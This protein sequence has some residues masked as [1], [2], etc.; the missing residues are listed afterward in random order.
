MFHTKFQRK[1]IHFIFH[2]FFPRENRAV[3]EIMWG[4]KCA[5]ARQATDDDAIRRMPVAYWTTKAINTQSEYVIIT[6]FPLQRR[7]LESDSLSCYTY[8][9]C[10]VSFRNVQ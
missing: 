4:K 7:L 6:A 10:L 1:S 3:Y 2:N 8:I 9:V 5:T